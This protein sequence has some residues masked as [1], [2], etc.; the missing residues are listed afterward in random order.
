ML[1]LAAVGVVIY[2]VIL[3]VLLS[4]SAEM[5]HLSPRASFAGVGHTHA[6]ADPLAM[7]DGGRVQGK[8]SV[9]ERS[10]VAKPKPSHGPAV[11]SFSCRLFVC[12]DNH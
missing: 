6:H 3:L 10:P 2:T 11:K 8:I 7:A 9:A 12:M 5:T 4:F 1:R